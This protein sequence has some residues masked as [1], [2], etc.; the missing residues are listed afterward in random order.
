MIDKSRE[1]KEKIIVVMDQNYPALSMPFDEEEQFIAGFIFGR[2]G[3]G[4]IITRARADDVPL[5]IL[6]NAVEYFKQF[7]G[8][9]QW[10][11]MDDR[12]R[13]LKFLSKE[14]QKM[15]PALQRSRKV[16][17]P[18]KLDKNGPLMMGSWELNESGL[19][20]EDMAK[21][22]GYKAANLYVNMRDAHVPAP[23]TLTLL[24]SFFEELL[25]Q[26][27]LR[28]RLEEEFNKIRK[29]PTAFE[30]HLKAMQ[31]M[32]ITTL[33]PEDTKVEIWNKLEENIGDVPYLILRLSTGA[34]DLENFPGVGAGV[35]G[36][37][38]LVPWA[39]K[40]KGGA[41][42]IPQENKANLIA[43]MLYTYAS[44]WSKNAFG[45]RVRFGIDHWAVGN[46]LMIQE[47]LTEAKY[48]VSIHTVDPESK[49]PNIMKIEIVPGS[50]AALTDTNSL[51]QGQALTFYYDKTA[52]SLIANFGT[53]FSPRRL[54]KRK[55]QSLVTG[56][57]TDITRKDYPEIW[58]MKGHM[59]SPN[60]EGQIAL[61]NSV[62][63][64][65]LLIEQHHGRP[66]DIEGVIRINELT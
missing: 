42:I 43:E 58:T 54:T 3:A 59:A 40:V 49:N 4:H 26:E 31:G 44:Y 36:S 33:V 39:K 19:S 24:N 7:N 35:Y 65:A 32:I 5:L 1:T 66:Q 11:S 20:L 10:V 21:K 22:M 60:M 23:K 16:A 17:T 2:E 41:Y 53:S 25:D 50:G 18:V 13:K 46:A 37:T 8:H 38:I 63:P 27:G 64:T 48:S 15:V 55:M 29:D 52:G 61:A 62:V 34:E 47:Y 56:N 57:I 45:D 30:D 9:N 6:P 28:D 51:L 12:E 14:E